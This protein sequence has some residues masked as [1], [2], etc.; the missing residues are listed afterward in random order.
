MRRLKDMSDPP[1]WP[2]WEHYRHWKRALRRW[3]RSTDVPVARRSDRLLKKLAWSVHI[4][5]EHISGVTLQVWNG[6]DEM[7]HLMDSLS[8]ER[9]GDDLRRAGRE[10]IFDLYM[11]F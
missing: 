3:N 4:K 5:F 1:D 9:E 2:G 7:L 11:A 6:I 8:G 10:A